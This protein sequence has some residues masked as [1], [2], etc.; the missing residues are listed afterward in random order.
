MG[1]GHS[2]PLPVCWEEK[3]LSAEH[4]REWRIYEKQFG[5]ESLFGLFAF[6]ARAAQS[7]G[8]AMAL[9]A[10]GAEL[11]VGW[12]EP[13]GDTSKGLTRSRVWHKPVCDISW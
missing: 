13:T 7:P 8:A 5:G 3:A 1:C 9:G 2:Q 4:G 11:R 6:L 12:H 10:V